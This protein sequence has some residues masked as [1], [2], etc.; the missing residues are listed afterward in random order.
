MRPICTHTHNVVSLF[1]TPPPPTWIRLCPLKQTQIFLSFLN[2]IR[3]ILIEINLN[4]SCSFPLGV[5]QTWRNLTEVLPLKIRRKYNLRKYVFKQKG[6]QSIT[7]NR[8]IRTRRHGAVVFETRRPNLEM[9][10]KST[11]YKGALEW[12]N[13]IVRNI[14][15]FAIFKE[16]QK[17]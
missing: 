9:Y 11:L 5:S 6:N 7:V 3:S 16:M 12:N 17:K 1:M 15:K 13:L 8:E 2:D 4:S 10:K 14:E